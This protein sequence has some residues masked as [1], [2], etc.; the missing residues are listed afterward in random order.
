MSR[1]V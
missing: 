1:P